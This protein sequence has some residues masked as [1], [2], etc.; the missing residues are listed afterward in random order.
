MQASNLT[1]LGSCGGAMGGCTNTN[2]PLLAI[3]RIKL[4]VWSMH[5]IRRTTFD[6]DGIHT[7]YLVWS[8]GRTRKSRRDPASGIDQA[9]CVAKQHW[10]LLGDWLKPLVAENHMC[11]WFVG[12][13][14]VSLSLAT[15][16]P[17]CWCCCVALARFV[18]GMGSDGYQTQRRSLWVPGKERAERMLADAITIGCRKEWICKFC[19]GTN[20]WTRWRCRRCFL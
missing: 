6:L 3:I 4:Q 7:P 20:V 9:L 12:I 13:V 5:G 8:S 11:D 2:H 19:S 17:L 14:F 1:K 15:V 10:D 16:L 18:K